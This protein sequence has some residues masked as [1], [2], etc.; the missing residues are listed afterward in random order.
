MGGRLISPFFR[1]RDFGAMACWDVAR[2]NQL[3][4]LRIR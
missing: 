4:R 2:C 3:W 1:W